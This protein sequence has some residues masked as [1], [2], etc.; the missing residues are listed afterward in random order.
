MWITDY[1]FMNWT[2][3]A[4][5]TANVKNFHNW[6]VDLCIQSCVKGAVCMCVIMYTL[7]VNC[8]ISPAAFLI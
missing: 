5:L 1:W 3:H 6:P 4:I 2:K 7:G 8:Q